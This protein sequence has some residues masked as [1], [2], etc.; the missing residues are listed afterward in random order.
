MAAL[1][2][3]VPNWRRLRLI[4]SP[5]TILR[6]HATLVR[7]RWT[8][9]RRPGR[10]RA[11][12][13]I[14]RLV[15]EM[16]RDDPWWGYRRIHGELVGLG[17]AIAASTV[18]KILKDAG[19]DPAPRRSGPTW[20]QFLTTQ[21][22]GILAVDFFHVDTVLLRR[23]YVLFVVEHDRRRVRIVGVTAHPTAEWVVQR[24]QNLLVELGDRVESLRFLI[25]DR[26]AKFTAAFDAV[27]ESVG[28]D[29]LRSPVRA[30]RAN[31]IAERWVGS[32][33]RECLDRMLVVNRRHLEQV[34]AEY[35]DHFNQHRPHRSLG[36]RA[37]DQVLV[38]VRMTGVGRV[39]R[40]DRLG[41][42][43]HEYQQVA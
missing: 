6:W 25:R 15:A 3:L 37:P 21:A 14:R 4:V 12:L 32:V 19:L 27:F 41:G 18:W 7:R 5:R 23:L 20:K 26:D 30:P 28:I 2:R 34:L 9:R 8:Y 42:L 43:I 39:R 38:P 36:Q 33:R 10:P 17:H 24:I 29:I 11:D 13:A 35:V 1:V 31:A 40:C 16:A 22:K